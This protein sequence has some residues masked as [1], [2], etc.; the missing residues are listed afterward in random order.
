MVQAQGTGRLPYDVLCQE[1]ELRAGDLATLLG[2]SAF[3]F[4]EFLSVAD[5]AIH[6]QFH[7]GLSGLTPEFD[8]ALG[9]HPTLGDWK[10]RV[11]EAIGS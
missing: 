7:F 8:A 2:S 4:A 6:G 3:F 9:H 11:E 10:K 5:L 1:L